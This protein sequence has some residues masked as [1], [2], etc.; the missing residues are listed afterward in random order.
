[1]GFGLFTLF[2]VVLHDHVTEQVENR[3]TENIMNKNA[4]PVAKN[5]MRSREG[6]IEFPFVWSGER[7]QIPVARS[8]HRVGAVA[9]GGGGGGVAGVARGLAWRG[10]PLPR[11]RGRWGLPACGGPACPLL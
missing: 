8:R 9:G 6:K 10:V 5:C 11:G 1:M 4:N 2:G 3:I 7:I